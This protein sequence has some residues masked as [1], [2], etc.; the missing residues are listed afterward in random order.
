MDPSPCL[1]KVDIVDIKLLSY[2]QCWLE[3]WQVLKE[4]QK[5]Q[6][7]SFSGV[8]EESA[9]IIAEYYPQKVTSILFTLLWSTDLRSFQ[10][11][12]KLSMSIR[13]SC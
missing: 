1:D 5:L 10:V 6:R 3:D 2:L 7:T 9:R 11:V 4:L 8:K 13:S 12:Y